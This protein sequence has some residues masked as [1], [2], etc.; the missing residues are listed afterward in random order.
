MDT[1]TDPTRPDDFADAVPCDEAHRYRAHRAVRA[2]PIEEVADLWDSSAWAC[3]WRATIDGHH[4]TI[5]WAKFGG[6]HAWSVHAY[7]G[8]HPRMWQAATCIDAVTKMR[9]EVAS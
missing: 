1:T 7:T 8:S 9:A 3:E 6:D 4:V 5:H 2:F